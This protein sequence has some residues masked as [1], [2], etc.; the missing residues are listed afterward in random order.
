MLQMY[1]RGGTAPAYL[2]PFFVSFFIISNCLLFTLNLIY[3]YSFLSFHPPILHAFLFF[4][5]V[6][7]AYTVLL[8]PLP[9][10]FQNLRVRKIR[11]ASTGYLPSPDD[12]TRC[13]AYST[14]HV[15]HTYFSSARCGVL[16]LTAE[17]LFSAW[18]GVLNAS[19]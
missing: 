16:T 9:S 13:L 8:P 7:P 18:S 3:D 17:P 6:F 1:V 5:D 10:R 2:G 19:R 15:L 4:G 11:V 12:M 14:L